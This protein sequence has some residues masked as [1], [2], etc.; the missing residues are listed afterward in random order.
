L[1]ILLRCVRVEAV[2][3]RAGVSFERFAEG[4][5]NRASR[6]ID[7]FYEPPMDCPGVSRVAR[8]DHEERKL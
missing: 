7:R 5:E 1:R 4:D 3:D 6:S 8:A 2:V